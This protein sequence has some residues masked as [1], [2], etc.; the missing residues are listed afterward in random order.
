L[1][2]PV[3]SSVRACSRTSWNARTSPKVIAT[4]ARPATTQQTASHAAAGLKRSPWSNTRT[5]RLARVQASGTASTRPPIRVVAS[6]R[7]GA[8]TGSG[9]LLKAASAIRVI[10]VSQVRSSG[11]PST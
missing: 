10:A 1:G 9:S 5:T 6:L 8:P 11:P 2:S 4:R 7:A 3:S